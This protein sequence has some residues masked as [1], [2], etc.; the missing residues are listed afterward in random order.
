MSTTTVI[1]LAII[2]VIVIIATIVT[3]K[4]LDLKFKK[5]TKELTDSLRDQNETRSDADKDKAKKDTDKVRSRIRDWLGMVVV[6]FIAGCA[7]ATDTL[8][9]KNPPPA[10]SPDELD[11][12]W[13]SIEKSC[14]PDESGTRVTCIK[15]TFYESMVKAVS[16]YEQREWWKAEATRIENDAKLVEFTGQADLD[17]AKIQ[18]W[19]FAASGL[20]LGTGLTLG[21]VLGLQ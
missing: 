14:I 1:G 4:I 18:R 13:S 16:F 11:V 6:L 2:L 12:W 20:V 17:S 10:E 3:W 9:I 7:G 8:A 15:A 19:I 21:L 5:S